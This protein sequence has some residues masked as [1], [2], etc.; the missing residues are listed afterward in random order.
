MPLGLHESGSVVVGILKLLCRFR[1]FLL[2]KRTAKNRPR[3][4]S[5]KNS[6]EE[7]AR[8]HKH[9]RQE[10]GE[11]HRRFESGEPTTAMSCRTNN[12]SNTLDN[13]SSLT[14]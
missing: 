1:R 9:V 12:P 3:Q 7:C 11:Y 13:G 4:T 10:K 14:R 8:K 5:F 2:L 6:I